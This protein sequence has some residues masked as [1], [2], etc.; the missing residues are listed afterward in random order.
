M[1]IDI[2]TVLPAM[3]YGFIDESIVKRARNK[4]LLEVVVHNLRDYTNYA[5]QQ[6]D[7]YPYGGGAGMVLMIEP[8]A[9]CIKTLQESRT[10]DAV[11]YM[12]P[13]GELLNQQVAN[14]F[15]LLNNVII[16]CGHY[17]GIDDRVRQ[18]LITHEVSIGNYVLTGG[19]LAAAVFTDSLTRLIPGVLGD[20][21]SALT[22]SFQDGL[23]A[24]PVYSRPETFEGLQVPEV[25]TSGN[26]ALIEQWRFEQSLERTRVRRPDLYHK[27]IK[28]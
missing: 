11:V 28:P 24:P 13:D 12:S 6:V 19:E 16:L 25:L 8:I 22:D 5:Q 1:R 7:D 3:L 17:K 10:Y 9:N 23:L 20:E 18:S 4:G 26:H 21:T 2:I 27:Y 15:S 14:R